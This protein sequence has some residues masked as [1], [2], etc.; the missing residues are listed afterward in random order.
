MF[1][2]GRFLDIILNEYITNVLLTPIFL[3]NLEGEHE[4]VAVLIAPS[5]LFMF[6]RNGIGL[7]MG[8]I[9]L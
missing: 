4:N 9:K 7:R 2:S 8:D 5:S 6:L 3:L 1:R